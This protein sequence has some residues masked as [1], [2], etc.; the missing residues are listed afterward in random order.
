MLSPGLT[1]QG[2]WQSLASLASMTAPNRPLW[3][4][5]RPPTFTTGRSLPGTQGQPL[6]NS[7]IFIAFFEQT[8]LKQQEVNG[9]PSQMSSS[10]RILYSIYVCAEG[11]APPR[12]W[13]RIANT[14]LLLMCMQL[15]TN[16]IGL[17]LV[18]GFETSFKH[19]NHQSH[20]QL[21]KNTIL[22][23]KIMPLT[24]L[25]VSKFTP[26]S[27]SVSFFWAQLSLLSDSESLGDLVEDGWATSPTALQNIGPNGHDLALETCFLRTVVT[28]PEWTMV[29]WPYVVGIQVL[30][31]LVGK[32]HVNN[33]SL[34]GEAP[35][36]LLSSWDL[37]TLP[38]VSNHCHRSTDWDHGFHWLI[39]PHVWT[40]PYVGF[41]KCG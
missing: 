21:E 7:A 36:C 22:S 19:L 41:L 17:R 29:T 24:S 9:W 23:S 2:F 8:D 15:A 11:K 32:K 39:I 37:V 6:A 35:Q 31:V 10:L 34:V 25:N 1:S 4:V 26:Y 20:V 28:Q 33:P 27:P 38:W 3:P 40:N 30:Q 12:G 16:S 5:N 18:R 14:A 13:M